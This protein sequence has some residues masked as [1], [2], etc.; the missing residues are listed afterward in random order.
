[1]GREGDLTVLPEFPSPKAV[2]FLRHVGP[3]MSG[4]RVIVATHGN[5]DLDAVASALLVC[6]LARAQKAAS[7]CVGVPE[8]PSRASREVMGRLGLSLPEC[9]M[10]EDGVDTVV[11][12]DASN[13][14]Q[15]GLE[16]ALPG[17]ASVAVIDHHE[18]GS[19]ASSSHL[20]YVDPAAPTCVELALEVAIAG[21]VEIHPPLA[22]I[23]LS[24]IIDESGAFD[25]T[26]AR[27]FIAAA[28]LLSSG[29]DYSAALAAARA[30][31]S[32]GVDLRLARLKAASRLSI[33]R[34]CG[35]LIVVVTHV[36][37]YEAEVARSLVSLGAD[38]AIVVKGDRASIRVSR[39]AVERGV[40]ASDLAAY[41]AG[42]LGGEGGGHRGAAALNLYIGQSEEEA[43]VRALNLA[44][45]YLGSKCR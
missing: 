39:S 32:E 17:Q 35:D 15:V 25:R 40:S 44:V 12:V 3:L 21:G 36:G 33:S 45:A 29:G 43:S 24:A 20:A 42:K 16:P 26:S 22:T 2:E 8:G 41:L 23:T 7:C 4:K 11:I 9:A 14:S 31:R 19:I 37:S 38:V 28:L 13:W 27:T 5:A 1:M 10:G 30:Q 34:A 6:E 18:P